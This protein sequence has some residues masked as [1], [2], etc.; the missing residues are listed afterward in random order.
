MSSTP[1]GLPGPH[2]PRLAAT[3]TLLLGAA[4][5]CV[6]SN[7]SQ[8]VDIVLISIDT[9]RPDHLGC[10]GYPQPTSPQLDRFSKDAVLFR[11]AVAHAPA[12]LESHASILTSLIPQ[13]HGAT[14]ARGHG[15]A[16]EAPTIAALVRAAGYRT[17]SF[18]G[19]GQLDEVFGLNRGFDLY[20]A[21]SSD[22]FRVTV[23]AGLDWL[24][25]QQG[26]SFLF[27]HTYETHHPYRPAADLLARFEPSPYR[28]S[29]PKTETP[30]GVLE[31]INNGKR[32]LQPGDLE[33][34]VATYD[35]TIRSVDEALGYFLDELRRQGRYD[36]SLIILTSDH[37]EEFGEHGKVG[38]HGHTLFDELL[39]VP[40]I[41]KFPGNRNAGRE[42]RRQVRGIDI[43]PTILQAAGLAIPSSFEGSSLSVEPTGGSRARFAVSRLVDG[44]SERACIRSERWKLCESE[45]YDLERDPRELS[46]V[47]PLEPTIARDLTA[48]LQDLVSQAPR[49]PGA[50]AD[51]EGEAVAALRALGYIPANAPATGPRRGPPLY[52]DRLPMMQSPADVVVLPASHPSLSTI[53]GTLDRATGTIRSDGREGYLQFGPYVYL[54]AGLYEIAWFGSVSGK[55]GWAL[56]DAVHSAGSARVASSRFELT[57]DSS[58]RQIASLRFELPGPVGDAEFRFYVGPEVRV[59]ISLLRVRHQ[60]IAE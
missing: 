27:L 46:N 60:V 19:G 30:I 38:W 31:E 33:H 48:R 3:L 44:I 36:N 5:A 17:A 55:A 53:V 41:V 37:G 43:A 1:T 21:P 14:Y 26:P 16:S 15:L 40:L 23:D 28:G 24:R 20:Q 54:S 12:T 10:Y 35:A 9:L 56:V 57:P 50:A 51:P 52:L 22:S 6:V 45:L 4:A 34:I 13:H 58:E 2:G 32:Q 42:I 7:P 25:A 47:R 18:N 39:R 8:P 49:L 29:L 59:G 11:T